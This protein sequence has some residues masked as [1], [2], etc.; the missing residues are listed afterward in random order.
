MKT[1]HE[2]LLSLQEMPFLTSYI[3]RAKIDKEIED[4]D[5]LHLAAKSKRIGNNSFTYKAENGLQ[6]YFRKN[7]QGLP[8]ELNYI[9][10]DNIQVLAYKRNGTVSTVIYHMAHH[11]KKY[12]E[13]KTDTSQSP[14][15]KHLWIN[16]IKSNPKKIKF[17]V[18]LDSE[19]IELDRENI[20]TLASKIWSD[21]LKGSE[22]II[23]A[24]YDT[25]D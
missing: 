16:F 5:K 15:A 2:Y 1:F 9:D 7:K 8:E 22:V 11:I 6:I 25:S 23:R 21:S 3:T 14:G 4:H 13:L 19:T 10:R 20:D 24:Y 17:T 18:E 12:G